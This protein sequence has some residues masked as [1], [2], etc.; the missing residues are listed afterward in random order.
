MFQKKLANGSFVNTPAARFARGVVMTLREHGFEAFLAG[1]CV[2]DAVLGLPVEDYDVATSARPDQVLPLFG[3]VVAT[4]IRYGT[5]TVVGEAHSVEVTTFREDADYQNGRHP[6]TLTFGVSAERDAERRD[7]TMNAMFADPESAEVLDYTGGLADLD[8]RCLRTVG[9]PGDRLDEDALRLLRGVRFAARFQLSVDTETS[10]AMRMRPHK[11]RQLSPERVAAELIKM[12]TGNHPGESLR[13]LENYQFLDEF[14]PEAAAM[15][16]VP[17]PPK[18]HP[19][20]DVWVHT[21]DVVERIDRRTPVL[22]L[23]ALFHDVGKVRTLTVTDRIRFHG[24]EPV[25]SELAMARMRQLRLSNELIE[26]VRELVDEHIRVGGFQSWRRAKQLRFLER[27]NIDDHLS[28]HFADCS[29]AHGM[30]DNYYYM[31]NELAQLRSRPAEKQQKPL[32]TGSDLLALGYRQG[33]GFRTILDAVR[34]GQ[35]EE[36]ITTPDE[37]RAFVEKNFPR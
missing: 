14:L 12:I 16:G 19:E 17:Q 23:A 3:H 20:G 18:Y 1:G 4:G 35:L 31:K 7:F 26:G 11:L 28:L 30:L 21:V 5:V 34:D 25:S 8:A 37:A 33:P 27:P 36:R 10:R 32:I 13:L 22:A 29:S 15:R 9:V 2:R 24:H 6:G